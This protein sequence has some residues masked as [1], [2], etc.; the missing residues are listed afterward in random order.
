MFERIYYSSSSINKETFPISIKYENFMSQID[1]T[2]IYESSTLCSKFLFAITKSTLQSIFLIYIESWKKKIGR[3]EE[4]VLTYS[5]ET[6]TN[7][8]HYN[9]ICIFLCFVC[10]NFRG[11]Q[12]YKEIYS[13]DFFP[14]NFF[15]IIWLH[16]ESLFYIK[17]RFS[18]SKMLKKPL[19]YIFLQNV[20]KKNKK[21]N[22][23]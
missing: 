5:N 6:S 7:S 18:L 12:R 10:S 2:L 14:K 20:W 3:R 13:K 19:H 9:I 15:L 22:T 23:F 11:L 1:K 21:G 4:N 16:F 8:F 17:I